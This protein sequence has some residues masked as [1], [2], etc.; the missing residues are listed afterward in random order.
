MI[1]FRCDRGKKPRR[2]EVLFLGHFSKVQSD[3]SSK[4]MLGGEIIYDADSTFKYGK[5]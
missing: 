4:V 5:E 2:S 1:F 3:F